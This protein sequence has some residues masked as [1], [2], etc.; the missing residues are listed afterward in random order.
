M[1]N[2]IEKKKRI[3]MLII[4]SK[5]DLNNEINTQASPFKKTQKP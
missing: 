1:R 4:K 3:L 2:K 5:K